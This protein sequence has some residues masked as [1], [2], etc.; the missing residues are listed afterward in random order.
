M[1]VIVLMALGLWLYLSPLMAGYSVHGLV[2]QIV[3][4]EE[5]LFEE[6]QSLYGLRYVDLLG[7]QDTV[8]A[9]R[10]LTEK[11]DDEALGSLLK[12]HLVPHR[13]NAVVG[14]AIDHIE[15]HGVEYG[16]KEYPSSRNGFGKNLF[17][18][19]KRIGK[20]DLMLT[21]TALVS[22]K[23][24]LR[25]STFCRCRPKAVVMTSSRTCSHPRCSA[26][27]ASYPSTSHFGITTIQN[28]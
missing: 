13:S 6:T 8:D 19:V 15:F 22:G 12:T 11:G 23:E 1:A 7:D 25:G 28:T 10:M 3:E 21:N 27:T 17:T 4:C 20:A 26:R 16:W 14:G 24:P 2:E 18:S 9:F 5:D